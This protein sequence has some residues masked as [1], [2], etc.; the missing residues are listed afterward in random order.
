[1]MFLFFLRSIIATHAAVGGAFVSWNLRF[2]DEE[3]CVRA[4]YVS[5]TLE[6]L[7]EFVG[8]TVCQNVLVFCHFHQVS[9]F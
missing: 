8:K 5:D 9:I 4:G 3:I 6:E 1:M 2:A 7:A